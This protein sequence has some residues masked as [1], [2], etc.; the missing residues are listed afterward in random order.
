MNNSYILSFYIGK[1]LLIYCCLTL[2][3][4]LLLIFFVDLVELLRR[5]D[6]NDQVTLALLMGIGLLRLPFLVERLLP[7]ILLFGVLFTCLQ[8]ARSQ[9]LIAMRAVG[10]SVWQF[11]TPALVIAFLLGTVSVLFYNPLA[12]VLAARAEPLQSRYIDKR[13]STLAISSGGVWLR[14]V[15]EQG[16]S[17]IHAQNAE[18]RGDGPLRLLK[19]N[20][21][22]YQEGERFAG[23]LNAE[24]AALHEGYWSLE[25]TWKI[26]PGEVPV[27]FDEYRQPTALTSDQIRESLADPDS[28]SFWELRDFIAHTQ[29]AGLSATRY[30]VHFQSLISTPLFLCAMMLLAVTI[31][32]YLSKSHSHGVALLSA[33]LCGGLLFFFRDFLQQLGASGVIPILLAV[34]ASSA[35]AICLSG[36]VLLHMEGG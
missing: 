17:V 15:D 34:W 27:F 10:M 31:V 11:L 1:K 36:A 29:A 5:S 22:F 28:I 20:V 33:A 18:E 6:G 8:F 16:H 7:L 21:F 3:A 24:Q 26:I 30:Q 9:E 14:Q 13:S 23:R 19:V 12:S 32:F 2:Y 35:I 25:Q 4:C